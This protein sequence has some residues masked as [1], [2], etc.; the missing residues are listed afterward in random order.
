[1]TGGRIKRGIETL[2]DDQFMLTY[3][4]GISNVNISNLITFYKENNF[5]QK[6]KITIPEA[7]QDYTKFSQIEV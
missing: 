2:K 1:M 3:G 4:D 5:D 7:L 6:G